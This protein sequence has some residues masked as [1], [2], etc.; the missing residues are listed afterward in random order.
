MHELTK[1]ECWNLLDR[2]S[3]VRLLYTSAGLPVAQPVRFVVRNKVIMISLDQSTATR[4]LPAG[5]DFVALQADDL[6]D[7]AQSGHSVTVYGRAQVISDQRRSS[8]EAAGLPGYEGKAAYVCVA[9]TQLSGSQLDL[10][11]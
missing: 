9:P 2:V 7:G 11:G 4:L 5:F 6:V 3:L 1:T 8:A 10:R